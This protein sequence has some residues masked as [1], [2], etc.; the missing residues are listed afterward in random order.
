MKNILIVHYGS[1]FTEK[2]AL[3]YEDQISRLAE[4]L[5]GIGIATDRIFRPPTRDEI[6]RFDAVAF[7]SLSFKKEANEIKSHTGKPVFM[8]TGLVER[9]DDAL[10]VIPLCKSS[11]FGEIAKRIKEELL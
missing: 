2:D 1:W 4:L 9:G 3:S 11:G 10:G 7:I 8:I 6:S 5:K